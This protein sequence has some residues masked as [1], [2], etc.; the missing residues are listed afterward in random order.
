M[1]GDDA[2]TEVHHPAERRIHFV[3]QARS[4]SQFASPD[5]R[6]RRVMHRIEAA[7][8]GHGVR[9]YEVAHTAGA[10]QIH[11]DRCLGGNAFNLKHLGAT[12]TSRQCSCSSVKA[13]AEQRHVGRAALTKCATDRATACAEVRFSTCRRN[14]RPCGMKTNG[15]ATPPVSSPILPNGSIRGYAA[16]HQPSRFAFRIRRGGR[17]ILNAE[18]TRD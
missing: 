16:T 11:F 12:S 15:F 18:L 17:R 7:G 13:C 6:A 4:R 10:A 14:S 1:R 5:R 3:A 8:Y 9:C 2:P